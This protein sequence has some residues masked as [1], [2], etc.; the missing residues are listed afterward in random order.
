MK[1]KGSA[2][3]LMKYLLL[4]IPML[5]LVIV[6]LFL[7]QRYMGLPAWVAWGGS[8]LWL[9]KDMLMFP[10]VRLAYHNKNPNT[11]YWMSGIQGRAV[12]MLDN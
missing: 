2:R 1:Q 4:Q 5:S 10:L 12:E 3:V 7:A 8:V 9:A 11:A 6:V